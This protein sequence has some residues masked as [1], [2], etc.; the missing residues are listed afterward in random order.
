MEDLERRAAA[1]H[2]RHGLILSL[3]R[4]QLQTTPGRRGPAAQPILPTRTIR[5]NQPC[6]CGSG[7]KWKS[8]CR[9]N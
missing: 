6:P 2:L 8:C 1:R 4:L 3:N 7:R 5:R 9:R